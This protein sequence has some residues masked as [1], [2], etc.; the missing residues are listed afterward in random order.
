MGLKVLKG[1]SNHEGMFLPPHN[2]GFVKP[3]QMAIDKKIL[4]YNTQNET[5]SKKHTHR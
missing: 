3:L 4:Q 5:D 1:K 2:L